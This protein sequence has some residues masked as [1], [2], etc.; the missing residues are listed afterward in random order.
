MK[1][2]ISSYLAATELLDHQHPDILSFVLEYRDLPSKTAATRL[3]NKVRDG[4]LYD[5]FHLDLRSE[6][7]VSSQILHK[8]RAWCVE[9]SILLASSLRALGIPSR[10]GFAIV[11]NHLNSDR[12]ISYLKKDEIVFHGYV[13][14]YIDGKWIRCTPAFDRRIC[15]ISRVTPLSWDGE[16]DSMFQEFEK[17]KKFMEYV[18]YYGEFDDVPQKLMRS[19]MEAHYPHLFEKDYLSKDFSF[20][21]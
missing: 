5:P 21:Y 1:E 16:T 17:E 9:K 2:D 4:Q 12:L 8:K 15:T 7:L 20:R 11:K 10:L 18:H 13:S 3:Y 19:E 14:V 6:A